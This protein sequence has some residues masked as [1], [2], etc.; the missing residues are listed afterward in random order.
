MKRT[1]EISLTLDQA[2][3]YYNSGIEQLKLLALKFYSEEELTQLK[4]RNIVDQ[5][6]EDKDYYYVTP[7]HNTN[8][9]L[10]LGRVTSNTNN[11]V[12]GIGIIHKSNYFVSA[13]I[14][15]L[16]YVGVLIK[17]KNMADYFNEKRKSY[18][19]ING[20]YTINSEMVKLDYNGVVFKHPFDARNAY[21]ILSEE[22]KKYLNYFKNK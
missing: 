5:L 11:S 17:V 22:E 19:Y 14:N 2:K 7:S 3:E 10:C 6:F 16:K 13:D 21:N 9:S 20:G 8:L 18:Q 15:F 1:R 12:S 4:Y